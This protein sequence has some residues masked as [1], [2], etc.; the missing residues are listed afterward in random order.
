M[1]RGLV[2]WDESEDLKEIAEALVEGLEEE[3]VKVDLQ[4]INS[5]GKPINFS[6]YD[7]VLVGSSHE[8]FFGGKISPK[9]KEFLKNCKGMAGRDVIAFVN[10]RFFG[11]SKA[12]KE[13]MSNL[14]AH[15]SIV[16]DFREF[17]GGEAAKKY[18]KV[19][20]L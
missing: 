2:I 1:K 7:V 19:I 14:E 4:G 13:V 20:G 11:T 5:I 16:R 15:G 3:G 17:E 10:S 6:R 12:L 18:I 8:G 9:L